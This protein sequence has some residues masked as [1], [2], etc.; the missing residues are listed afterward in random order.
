MKTP[1]ALNAAH[2]IQSS[3]RTIAQDG[4]MASQAKVDAAHA[5]S[6]QLK[7]AALSLSRVKPEHLHPSGSDSIQV[8][9]LISIHLFKS[10][11]TNMYL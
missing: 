10:L 9:R 8:T 7:G 5:A 6:S 3:R 4:R 11:N 1:Q 2:T